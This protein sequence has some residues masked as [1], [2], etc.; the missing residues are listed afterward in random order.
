MLI[1]TENYYLY[2]H[3]NMPALLNWDARIAVKRRKER[4]LT[5]QEERN[6]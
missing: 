1:E 3:Y 4:K 6:T 2:I 5:D